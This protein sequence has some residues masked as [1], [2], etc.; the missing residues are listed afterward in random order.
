MTQKRIKLLSKKGVLITYGIL[1]L[2]MIIGTFFDMNINTA[3]F[4]KDNAFATFVA[5]Y[6]LYPAVPC[7]MVSLALFIKLILKDKKD[8]VS[9]ICGLFNIYMVYESI[10]QFHKLFAN[11]TGA[12]KTINIAIGLI[13]AVLLAIY[14]FVNV[15]VSDARRVRG[16]AMVILFTFSA[17]FLLINKVIKTPWGR[18]R[19]R[20]LIV[21]EGMDFRP[22]YQAGLTES[23]RELIASGIKA[24][25]FK[26]FPSGHAGCAACLVTLTL[27]TRIVPQ[28]KD[29]ENLFTCIGIIWSLCTIL[30][31]IMAGAHF[32]TDVTMATLITFTLF[33]AFDRLL[34]KLESN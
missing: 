28:W 7:T 24:D 29:K 27:L 9:Y 3:L 21:T 23:A 18:P 19:F 4:H 30:G 6:G 34:D 12:Y 13:L 17:Q 22:W 25:E 26:S 15:D 8:V 33:L 16:I 31:R 14:V 20:T 11:D 1:V 5:H 10:R 2:F 32:L